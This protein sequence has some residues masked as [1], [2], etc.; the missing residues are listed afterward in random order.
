MQRKLQPF[1]INYKTG[2]NFQLSQ[3]LS[4]RLEYESTLMHKEEV[5]GLKNMYLPD[6]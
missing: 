5:I 6:F 4:G 1:T 2:Q 3:Q